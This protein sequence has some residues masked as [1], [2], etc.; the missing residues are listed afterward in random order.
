[1]YNY[2]T[3]KYENSKAIF[4]GPKLI[5]LELTHSESNKT[6]VI[7][8]SLNSYENIKEDDSFTADGNFIMYPWVGRLDDTKNIE[9][10]T[11]NGSCFTFRDSKGFPLHGLFAKEERIILDKTE[12]YIKIGI[13]NQSLFEFF[14]KLTE[15]FILNKNNF[16]IK[17]T[18]E[19]ITDKVQYFCYGYHPYFQI[20]NYSID[21]FKIETNLNKEIK[22]NENLVPMKDNEENLVFKLSNLNDLKIDNIKFDNLYT[23]DQESLNENAYLTLIDENSIKITIKSNNKNNQIKLHYFQIYTP[24]DRKSIAIEPMSAPS[25]SF[26]INFPKYLLEIKPNEILYGEIAI[27]IN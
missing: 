1:M 8:S 15:E 2:Q 7:I 4:L 14:P 3:L 21:N 6:Y 26:N 11:E 12:N 17:T 5:N 18:F 25:N 19:N 10:L 9:S 23:L 22:L 27:E 20:N 16:I 24:E 13:S